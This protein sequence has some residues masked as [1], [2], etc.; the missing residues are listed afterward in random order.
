MQENVQFSDLAHE[1][2]KAQVT[3]HWVPHP[4]LGIA[5]GP[6]EIT[7][8]L[9]LEFNTNPHIA[10]FGQIMR[11]NSGNGQLAWIRGN[12]QSG[13]VQVEHLQNLCA[14]ISLMSWSQC[15]NSVYIKFR[16][17]CITIIYLIIINLFNKYLL[18]T[19]E[20]LSIMVSVKEP[21]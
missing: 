11:L 20:G 19:Y 8:Q 15:R 10:H 18:D 4:A 5:K 1:M 13:L 21:M 7:Y 16:R 2:T 14:L 12:A 3:F 9:R 6:N 17:K